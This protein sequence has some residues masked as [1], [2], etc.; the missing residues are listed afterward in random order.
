MHRFPQVRTPPETSFR[1]SKEN[2][3][4]QQLT[5]ECSRRG[6]FDEDSFEDA[7]LEAPRP[8]DTSKFVKPKDKDKLDKPSTVR[9]KKL[10]KGGC[11][12]A[13][14]L[15]EWLVRARSLC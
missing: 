10:K 6:L 7:V 15:L 1:S 3:C 2:L 13:S 5:A 14:K 8:V 9:I 12:S 11:E 4:R